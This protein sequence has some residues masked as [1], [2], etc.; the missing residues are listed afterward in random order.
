MPGDP[1]AQEEID[2]A[3]TA[4]IAY[5]GNANAARK[6]LEQSGER[7]PSATTLLSWSRTLHW[8]RYEEL[9]EKFSQKME[10]TLAANYLDAARYATET[11]M[12]A[13]DKARER[14]EDG[15]DDD[16]GRTAANLSRVA[17]S[18]TD[19]RRSRQGTPTQITET[20]NLGEILRSLAAKGIV[21]LPDEP[22]QIEA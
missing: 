20:R 21:Q 16:P 18:A 1:Y 2:T 6:Y 15:R 3:L 5:A 17:Q 11:A 12:L 7:A 13:V 19:K 10:N 8:E 4:L 14:L 9:R 22:A